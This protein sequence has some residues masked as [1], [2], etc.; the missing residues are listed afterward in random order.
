MTRR[1][2]AIPSTAW[3]FGAIAVAFCSS[4]REDARPDPRSRL[5]DPQAARRAVESSLEEWRRSPPLD[6]TTSTIRP[7]MFVDQ[8]RRPGQRLREFAVLGE[9]EMDGCRRFQVK[10][11]MEDADEPI[12][13]AYYV[14]GQDPI[15][16]YRAE[17]FD[18]IMHMDKTMMEARAAEAA[19]PASGEKAER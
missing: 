19:E 5:T 12:L 8:Q 6:L 4:C 15:W 7:V 10:L 14:F 1:R 13:T 16:V 9:A 18:M 2:S 11:S 17:D 3:I